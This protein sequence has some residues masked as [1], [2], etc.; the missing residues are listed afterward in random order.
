MRKGDWYLR[1]GAGGVGAW[2]STVSA[3]HA[4][5]LDPERDIQ[6]TGKATIGSHQSWLVTSPQSEAKN[7]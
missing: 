3:A 7:F 2:L 6:V 4:L 1:I 5:Y